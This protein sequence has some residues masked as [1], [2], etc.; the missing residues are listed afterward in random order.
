MSIVSKAAKLEYFEYT[1]SKMIQWY[2]QENAMSTDTFSVVNDFSKLKV[3][4]LHFF[5]CAINS[6]SNHMLEIFDSFYA[7]PYGHVESELYNAMNADELQRFSFTESSM[8]LK[9]DIAG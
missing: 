3:L 4:K 9:T 7:M 5:V 6:S 8:Q 1:I 2:C